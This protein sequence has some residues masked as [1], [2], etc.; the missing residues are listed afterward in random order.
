MTQKK[1]LGQESSQRRLI[2]RGRVLIHHGANLDHWF[3]QLL[4]RQDITQAQGWVEDLTHCACV[5][6]TA[7][8][9]E[10]LQAWERGTGIAKFGVMVVL[11]NV[12]ITRTGKIDQCR[13]SRETHGH[14]KRELMRRSDIDDFRRPL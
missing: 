5:D 8:V 4:R 11:E 13:S 14:A 10:P 12:R 1:S 3:D 2:N 6:D 7:G 9:I